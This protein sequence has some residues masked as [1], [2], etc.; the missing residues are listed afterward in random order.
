MLY[1]DCWIGISRGILY[2]HQVSIWTLAFSIQ[3]DG[4]SIWFERTLSRVK[5]FGT[6]AS[7]WSFQRMISIICFFISAAIFNRPSRL[8]HL[9]LHLGLRVRGHEMQ[10]IWPNNYEPIS[11]VFGPLLYACLLPVGGYFHI[12]LS[13][14]RLLQGRLKDL[15]TI[16]LCGR[17]LHHVSQ[18][19]SNSFDSQTSLVL[20]E[21]DK[22]NIS[23]IF[24]MFPS[25]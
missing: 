12:Y 18:L 20:L 19:S 14:N 2:C 25:F 13:Q 22:G 6:M 11:D 10:F 21:Q 16:R 17:T 4:W 24:L 15:F 7:T 1:E 9:G 8:V 5:F 23:K 3:C